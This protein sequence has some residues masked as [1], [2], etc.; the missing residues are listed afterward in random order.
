MTTPQI[1]SY[2]S[3]KSPITAQMIV[4]AANGLGR[5][6]LDDD[7]MYWIERRPSEGGRNALVR[8]SSD[9]T[10]TDMLPQPFNART[11]VHEYGGGDFTVSNG[12]IYFSNFADQRLY[13]LLPGSEPVPITPE[14]ALRFAD[15]VIDQQR[16]LLFCVCEDHTH[17]GQE[18]VNSLVNLPLDEKSE[19]GLQVIAS[20][21]DFYST[22]RLSP[23]GSR[24]TWLTWNHPNMPWDG[25]EL[26]VA[27]LDEH[28]SLS[29]AQLVAGS[30]TLSVG[31]P[32]WSPNGTLHFVSEQGNGWWNLYRFRSNQA[33]PLY[34]MEA[35]FS[36]PQWV[37]GLS[38]YGFASDQQIICTYMQDG[39]NHL[40]SLNTLTGTLSN[41][42]LP[43]TTIANLQV[44][45]THALF[46]AASPTEPAVLVR[47][48]L[49]N[50]QI[51]ILRRSREITLDPSYFSVP[52]AIEFPTEHGK[53]A[54]AFFYPPHNPDFQAPAGE[55]PPLLVE[56][57]GGPT[58][59]TSS[60]FNLAL[61]FWT[62]RGI[63]VLDVNYGGSTGFG[64]EYR[65]RLNGQWGVV[66]VDDCVNG[67]TY[68][69]KRGLVDGKRLAITGG[70]AGGYTVLCALTFRDTFTV[71]ASHFGVSDIAAL[72]QETHKFESR[73][74]SSLIGPYPESATLYKERS[75]IY[76][77]D[78]LSR[79]IIFFQ[80]LEDKIVLPNQSERMVDALR[81]KGL[82]VAYLTF[83]GEQ[84]GF[85]R[86]ENI[87]R[88][89][90]GELYFY[91]RILAF[92]LADEI[93]PVTIENL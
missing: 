89:L 93:E 54:H 35:E 14:R 4:T 44:T 37:F 75:P 70:S 69:V 91:S 20:G 1:A 59:S 7:S 78:R 30:R 46:I 92:P 24:L 45:P 10:I 25:A 83:E 86:A 3:W 57:H 72:A 36:L 52:Q 66:D 23:D 81:Q 63:G 55:L 58:S 32:Q 71:G 43:Y 17:E 87:K 67:A 56:I 49:A 85:R 80:G 5:I 82:P 48:T 84:H 21:N 9:G 15:A 34:P 61:Q 64:R 68:L 77:T 6:V 51:E 8:R 65:Q 40:A 11:R 60:A 38:T 39:I 28:G 50:G 26:W 27:D 42:E 79:P 73:Y 41:Y 53:T 29:N 18:A 12:V 13:R 31:Q 22:P 16:N 74:D 2:G 47:L 90:E 76:H 19:K 62:S 88:A 33:E